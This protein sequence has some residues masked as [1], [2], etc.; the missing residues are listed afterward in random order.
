MSLVIKKLVTINQRTK[1]L[2]FNVVG[3]LLSR[4]VNLGS[5]LVIV[6]LAIKSLGQHEYG[7]FAII[8]AASVVFNYSDFGLGLSVVS[9]IAAIKDEESLKEAHYAI[10]NV[11]Y[12]LLRLSLII[13]IFGVLIIAVIATTVTGAQEFAWEAWLALI[14]C[15]SIGLAPGLTQRIFFGLQRNLEA[16]LW[17]T[18]GR[19]SSVFGVYLAYYFNASIVWFIV[20]MIG[21]PAIVGWLSTISLWK[22]TSHLKPNKSK[23]SWSGLSSYMSHGFQFLFLQ[24]G[25]FFETGMDNILVG[26]VQGAE[27]VTN[28]DLLTRLFI[29]VPALISMLAFPLWPAI[30]QAKASG[31]HEWVQRIFKI[32]FISIFLTSLISSSIFLYFHASIINLWVG[33]FYKPNYGLALALASFAV[34]TSLGILQAML[35]SGLGLISVQVRILAVFL[36][37]L[38]PGKF[39]ALKFSGQTLMVFVLVF[40]YLIK[41]LILWFMIRVKKV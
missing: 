19:M 23:F 41:I 36:L 7:I 25:V 3:G 9:K 24:T 32:S 6:P 39:L 16:N 26:F 2:I 4:I 35:M 30:S 17:N 1:K 18:A 29:Y 21:L 20:S 11:W 33:V 13:L 14:F 5:T 34:L 12:F 40:L 38:I 27:Y 8:L 22:W 28:Y 15:I 31:D 10:S 37:V